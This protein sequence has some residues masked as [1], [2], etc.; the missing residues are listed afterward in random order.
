MR[1]SIFLVVLATFFVLSVGYYDISQEHD[2]D[3]TVF[4]LKKSP[5]FKMKFINPRA[6]TW[7]ERSLLTE[8][9]RQWAIDYCKY[10]LGID[11]RLE[12]S[13]DID[14]CSAR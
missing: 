8:E 2:P 4:F 11:T 5:T 1:L 9:E 3:L 6:L 13:D 12:H 14:R 10:R 7:D